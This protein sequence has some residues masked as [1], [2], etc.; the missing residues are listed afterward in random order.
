MLFPS[1]YGN[2]LCLFRKA[3]FSASP[4][5]SQ[6]FSRSLLCEYIAQRLLQPG[7]WGGGGGRGREYIF[8]SLVKIAKMVFSADCDSTNENNEKSCKRATLA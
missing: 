5:Q 7:K 4:L 8:F 6:T 2:A 3:V 1:A